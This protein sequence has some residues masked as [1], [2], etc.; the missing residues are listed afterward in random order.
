MKWLG[1]TLSIKA[2]SILGV[3]LFLGVVACSPERAVTYHNLTQTRVTVFSDGT[4]ITSLE[5]GESKAFSFRRTQMPEHT[6][7]FTE[8]GELILD[9]VITWEIL[10]EHDFKIIISDG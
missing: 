1:L 2:V 4:E 7:V 8:M 3:V 10:E 5:P 9:K 6:E